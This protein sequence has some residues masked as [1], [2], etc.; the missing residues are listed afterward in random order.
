MA[1]RRWDLV[2]LATN[3]TMDRGAKGVENSLAYWQQYQDEVYFDG[4]ATSFAERDAVDV[5]EVN[6]IS[7]AFLAYTM[8]NNGLATPS[9]QEYLNNEWNEE[10]A[11]AQVEAVRDQVDIV[12]VAMQRTQHHPASGGGV[13]AWFRGGHYYWRPSARGAAD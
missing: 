8:W 6:G 1:A 9:G 7:Y 11:R 4:S 5:R 12:I 13:F 2:S 3:H 10:L